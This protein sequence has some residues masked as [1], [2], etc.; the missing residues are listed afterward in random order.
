MAINIKKGRKTK[1]YTAAMMMHSLRNQIIITIKTTG[2]RIPNPLRDKTQ[3]FIPLSSTLNIKKS[4]MI[5]TLTCAQLNSPQK[6]Q[7][8][9]SQTQKMKKTDTQT[10]RV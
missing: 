3:A 6:Y 4:M 7:I 1:R 9:H 10:E 5:I 8:L 2:N